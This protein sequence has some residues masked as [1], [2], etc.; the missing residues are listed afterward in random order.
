MAS[1]LLS[2]LLAS[3]SCVLCPVGCICTAGAVLPVQP[4]RAPCALSAGCVLPA[5]TQCVHIP[6][7]KPV[8]CV[9][10]CLATPP[11]TAQSS[12]WLQ[13]RPQHWVQP[14][15]QDH[16]QLLPLPL[17]GVGSARGGG[18]GLLHHRL[19]AGPEE[20]VLWQGKCC[21]R[22]RAGQSRVAGGCCAGRCK[23][24]RLLPGA[25]EDGK[26]CSVLCKLVVHAVSVRV[27]EESCLCCALGCVEACTVQ[28][29]RVLCWVSASPC[30][31]SQVR[32][33]SEALHSTC[34]AAHL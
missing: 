14:A 8:C 4:P 17:D 33:A 3:A 1:G 28:G 23:S 22:H 9:P 12:L 10:F 24:S 27:L 31:A 32:V 34:P 18:P 21:C 5:H 7:L 25:K 30:T 20:D 11:L 2:V 16:L 6:E 19:P 29:G 26:T 13:V 15:E